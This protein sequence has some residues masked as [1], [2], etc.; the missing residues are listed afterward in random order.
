[1]FKCQEILKD[2]N[3]TVMGDIISILKH[4][5]EVHAQSEREKMASQM[6]TEEPAVPSDTPPNTAQ[7]LAGTETPPGGK[8]K[9]AGNASTLLMFLNYLRLPALFKV[10][11]FKNVQKFPT[12]HLP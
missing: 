7:T 5:K 4:A 2:M 6:P 3:I 10:V 11:L 1:M 8:R 12:L 9:A